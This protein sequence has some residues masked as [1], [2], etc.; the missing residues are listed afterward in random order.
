MRAGLETAVE[1]IT[2][3]TADAS[4]ELRSPVSFIRTVAEC[5]LREGTTDAASREA[6][7]EIVSETEVAASLLEDMLTVGRAGAGRADLGFPP[8][9]LSGLIE[10]VRAKRWRAAR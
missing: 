3:F 7:Q 2:R 10:E 5:A 6:F 8:V 4:H 9:R 1:R